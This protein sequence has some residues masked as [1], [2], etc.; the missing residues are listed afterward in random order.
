MIDLKCC[1]VLVNNKAEYIA[2]IKEA[3]K[4]RLHMGGWNCFNQYI[5]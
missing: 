1:T 4:A 2:L 3:Q 5:L